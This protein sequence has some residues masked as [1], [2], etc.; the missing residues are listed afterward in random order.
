MNCLL[1][2]L[3]L[4]GVNGTLVVFEKREWHILLRGIIDSW[5]NMQLP[6]YFMSKQV[7]KPMKGTSVR[8]CDFAKI[9]NQLPTSCFC[10]VRRMSI[11]I[12]L[13]WY[14]SKTRSI[15]EIL[16]GY[17]TSYRMVQGCVSRQTQFYEFVLGNQGVP[18]SGSWEGTAEF[19]SR[20]GYTYVFSFS[21]SSLL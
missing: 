5:K 9:I 20:S 14:P 7:N 15:S 16:V 2:V 3:R 11:W 8:Y 17:V 13:E 1:R 19:C 6:V 21:F 10:V 12:F 4:V 18:L